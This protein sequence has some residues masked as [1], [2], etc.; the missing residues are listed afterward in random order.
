MTSEASAPKKAI[1]KEVQTNQKTTHLLSLLPT[2][3]V[4]FALFF[5]GAS[6]FNSKTLL[7]ETATAYFHVQAPQKIKQ[8]SKSFKFRF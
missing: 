3:S 8:C 7:T 4:V 5:C 6:C 1:R 2:H